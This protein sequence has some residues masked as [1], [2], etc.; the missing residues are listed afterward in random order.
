MVAIEAGA[1]D[2]SED[3]DMLTVETEPSDLYAIADALTAAGA[4]IESASNELIPSNTITLD[5]ASAEKILNL[6]DTLE[7]DPDIT[8]IAHNLDPSSLDDEL[9]E[10]ET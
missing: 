9:G 3:D 1:I 10:T 8:S 4:D 5:S 7:E 2:V 6:I